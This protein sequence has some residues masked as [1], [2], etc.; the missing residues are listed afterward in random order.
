MF[1][2][3]M[4][5][6]TH[7]SYRYSNTLLV[8]LNNRIYFRDHPFP[9][10][11]RDSV[12]HGPTHPSERRLSIVNPSSGHALALRTNDTFRLDTLSSTIDPEKGKATSLL[13][14]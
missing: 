8:S 5:I 1:I 9:G 6:L 12:Y 3:R 14:T 11:S 7:S 2:I 10:V 13:Q 4:V